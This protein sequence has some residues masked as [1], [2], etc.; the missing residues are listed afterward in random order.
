MTYRE[1]LR[2]YCDSYFRRVNRTD[3]IMARVIGD[4]RTASMRDHWRATSPMSSSSTPSILAMSC[5][6]RR[7]CRP[8]RSRE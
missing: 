4:E 8:S 6:Q 7:L 5:A 3:V 2:E 1:A